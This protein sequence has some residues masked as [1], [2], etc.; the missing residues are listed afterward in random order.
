MACI[1]ACFARVQGFPVCLRRRKGPDGLCTRRKILCRVRSICTDVAETGPEHVILEVAT[2][3]LQEW[4]AQ[5]TQMQAHSTFRTDTHA[6]QK[7]GC[8]GFQAPCLWELCPTHPCSRTQTAK[9]CTQ[10]RQSMTRSCNP[11]ELKKSDFSS[12]AWMDGE[13]TGQK[14]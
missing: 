6:V 12:E 11:Q 1:W 7:R 10:K 13:L 5:Q 4:V 14:S 8:S 2:A 3:S 9:L